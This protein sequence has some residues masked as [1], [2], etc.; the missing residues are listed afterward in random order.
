MVLS[1]ED[2]GAGQTRAH[3]YWYAQ[4]IGIF[5]AMVQH[6]GRHSQSSEPQ[7]MYFLWVQWYGQDLKHRAGWNAKRLH[8][9]RFV[10]SDDPFAFGFLDPQHVIHGVHLIPAFSYGHTG[11]LLQQNSIARSTSEQ[12]ED[13]KFYY[14]GM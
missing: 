6:T 2:Q 3:P 12:G 8:P 10:D 4:I 7:H 11:D 14:M 1:H 5:H 13:W 9:V